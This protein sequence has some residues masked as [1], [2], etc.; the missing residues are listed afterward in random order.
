M[1]GPNESPINQ[2]VS[3]FPSRR[4]VALTLGGVLVGIVAPKLFSG[5]W[6]DK[7]KVIANGHLN[8]VEK[9]TESIVGKEFSELNAFL[10][11]QKKTF[12]RL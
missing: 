8:K 6:Y 4:A 9:D 3:Q 10:L 2:S 7:R 1:S 5:C 12:L 11:P